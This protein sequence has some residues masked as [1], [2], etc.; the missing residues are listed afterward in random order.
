MRRVAFTVPGNAVPL[1][2]FR[3]ARGHSY[4]P[5]RVKAWQ[6]AVGWAA[7]IAMQG[8]EPFTG[9]LR[10]VMQF[11]LSHLRKVDCGN[12]AKGTEDSLQGIVFVNDCQTVDECIV[13]RQIRGGLAETCITV[14]EIEGVA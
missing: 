7:R 6:N 14:E 1:Q 2:S 12:L 5:A 13:K 4:Q 9:P 3:Y 10:I 8:R 11:H